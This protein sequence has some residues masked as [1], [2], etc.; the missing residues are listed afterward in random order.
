MRLFVQNKARQ[1]S[2]HLISFPVLD[3]QAVPLVPIWDSLGQFNCPDHNEKLTYRVTVISAVHPI[4]E[5]EMNNS[6]NI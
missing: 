3:C 2:W 1:V 5:T 4:T 6:A